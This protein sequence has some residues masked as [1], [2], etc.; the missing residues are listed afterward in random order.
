MGILPKILKPQTFK[1]K[2]IFVIAILFSLSTMSLTCKKAIARRRCRKMGLPADCY[3]N[4]EGREDT[5]EEALVNNEDLAQMMFQICNSDSDPELSWQEVEACDGKY[6]EVAPF[7]CPDKKDFESYD[8][9]KSGTIS[10]S[11][12]K[13]NQE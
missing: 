7:S 12:W 10:R 5:N 3:K 4:Q 2:T 6:C 13:S 1:M 11:E 8:M 9:D